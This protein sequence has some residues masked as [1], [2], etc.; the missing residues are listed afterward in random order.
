MIKVFAFDLDGTLT[1]HKTPLDDTNRSILEKL[2]S[3][4]TLLMVGAGGCM[5]IH[6]QMGG[7]P[8]DIIG[9]YGMQY[10][11]FTDG[12]LKLVRDNVSPCADRAAV[13]EKVTM[14]REKYGFTDFAG[15]NVEYHASG[16]L[17]FPLLG[18][19]AAPADKLAFDPDRKK[20]RA[21]YGEV[22][23]LFS[24]Y[25]VFVGG[26]SS[27]DMAPKPFNKY[28]A[29][30]LWCRENGY[31]HSEVVFVGDDYGVGGNDESVYL[32]DFHFVCTDDY[33]RLG[34]VLAPW[35]DELK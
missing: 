6:N 32:S 3:K 2:A 4:Y 1:Q 28:Y 20:R 19:K 24:D 21:F 13:E 8:V 10:A 7:F 26:S 31:D 25:N 18:T 23:E 22:C 11:K 30:D 15:D 17:T 35:L 34:E 12:E 14:L 27:F 33:T 16:C 9:N 5:R 29:L